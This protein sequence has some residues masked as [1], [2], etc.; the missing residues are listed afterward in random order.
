MLVSMTGY[1]AAERE[2]DQVRVGAEIRTVNNR[3]LKVVTKC[4]DRCAA[5]ASRI[6]RLVRGAMRR[7]SVTV[8]LRIEPTGDSRAGVLDAATLA[9]YC[10][11]LTDAAEQLD[12]PAGLSLDR[13]LALPGVV[14]D[15]LDRRTGGEAEWPLICE[16]LEAAIDELKRF[17][18]EEGRSIDEDLKRQCRVIEESLGQVAARAP[19]VV[20]EYRDRILVRVGDL[21]EQAGATISAD[22]VIR[23]VSL[24]ADRAD[25]NEELT[26]L[27]SHLDQ[28]REVLGD[29]ES[30]GRKLEFLGQEMVREVNTIG[31]KANDVEISRYVVEMKSAIDRIRENLQNVE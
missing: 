22:N 17:R 3:Y 14:S 30:Q 6:E 9:E 26:R 27:K 25:I 16:T 8:V 2:D 31:S 4:P 29:G 23:E 12:V 5:L 15:G 19:R 24:F 7:G 18:V 28:F 13:L 1:G 11:Q 20:T 10:R 21:L